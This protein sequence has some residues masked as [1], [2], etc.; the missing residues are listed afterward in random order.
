M[1][2][3]DQSSGLLLTNHI[4]Q[5]LSSQ[6]LSRIRALILSPS[7]PHSTITSIFQT[8]ARSLELY[9]DSVIL[10][11]TLKL[12]SDLSS[13]RPQFSRLVFD[14]V[15]SCSLLSSASAHIAAQALDVVVSIAERDPASVP[16]VNELD[17]D[18]FFPFAVLPSIP[19]RTT[20]ASEE[21]RE[22]SCSAAYFFN[23]ISRDPYPCVRRAALDGLVR[24]SESNVI[25]DE[26]MVRGCY[27]RAVDLLRDMEDSVRSAAVRAVCAWGLVLAASNPETKLQC[28]DELFVKVC[29]MARDMSVEVRVE[30][31]NALRK[32]EVVSE[33]ILL[34]TLSKKLL[35]IVKEKR[36]LGQCC[37]EQF[38]VLAS[39]AAGAL[40]H[41]LEDEFFEVRK[42]A[43]HS[44]STLIVLSADFAREALNLLMDVL[45]DGSVIVR[46]QAL[47]TMH[48]M[49]SCGRLKLQEKHVH[50]FLGPLVDKTLP[51]RCATKRILKLVKLSVLK[52]FTLTVD[53][54]LDN[55]A[56]YLEDEVDTFSALFHFGRNN[57]KFVVSII[58]DIL[59]QIEPMSDGKLDFDN[60]RVAGLLV[61]AISVPLSGENFSKI[62]HVVFSYALTMLGRITNSVSDVMDQTG[63]L[64]YLSQCSNSTSLSA[65]ELKEWGQRFPMVKGNVQVYSNENTIGSLAKPSQQEI[66]GTSE[67]QFLDMDE[68]QKLTSVLNS[69]LE[70]H[71]EIIRSINAIT[72]RVKDIW[73]LVQSGCL[74]Q[75]LRILRSCKEELALFDSNSGESVGALS[76]TLL[77]LRSIEVLAKVWGHFLP[78][79]FL[80][81]R[82]GTLN[83]LFGKLERR[84]IE[85]RGRF[86]CLSKEEEL[87]VLELVLLTCILKLYKVEIFCKHDTLEKL[88]TTL[89][90]VENLVKEGCI[91]PSNFVI[92]VGKLSAE[93]HTSGNGESY[94]RSLFRRLLEMFCLKEIMFVGRLK[95]LNTELII[96]NNGPE[97]PI[98]YVPGLP[99]GIACQIT[100][101]N[102]SVESRLWLKMTMDDG[103]TQFIFLDLNNFEECNGYRRFSFLAPFYKTPKAMSFSIRLCIGI[104]CPFEDLHFVKH[105]RVGPKHKLAYLCKEIE[106]FLSKR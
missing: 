74:H 5:P 75:V 26:D 83:L 28:S 70:A 86:I 89:S 7:T 66:D 59:Q 87:H 61:L 88:S 99:V 77:Y 52:L 37:G 78:P 22:V 35:G 105:R 42:S 50:T 67:I 12:L 58:E 4:Q 10:H 24:L 40:M 38:E 23:S 96:P 47:E 8:L 30:A 25:E 29:S 65:I 94:D 68:P 18:G 17:D 34:Q 15:R 72:A 56:R 62:P 102:I 43:C 9:R 73:P 2:D 3:H 19:V 92:E 106:V 20:M 91:Q 81:C 32:I 45:N 16:A 97:N 48:C 27:N 53:A 98:I 49:A 95:Y 101:H 82:I 57:G 80:T 31:F 71:D 84:L 1:E 69:K 85:L 103:S 76:F 93:I 64:A 104:E 60:V 36:S 13:H 39:S 100:I 55:L 63:L 46:L 33:D 11:Q 51:I 54:L 90:Q 14:S 41:G 6:S 21:R 79:K 44:L